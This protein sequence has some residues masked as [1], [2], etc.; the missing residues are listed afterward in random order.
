MHDR[1]L[2]TIIYYCL[3]RIYGQ[4]NIIGLLPNICCLDKGDQNMYELIFA[5]ELQVINVRMEHN[6]E[7]LIKTT[8]FVK[9][10]KI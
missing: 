1:P 2:Q 3:I 9:K 8:L 7:A 10:K 6:D 5:S 4:T